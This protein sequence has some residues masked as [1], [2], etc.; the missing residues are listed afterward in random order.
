MQ[1]GIAILGSFCVCYRT[2]DPTDSGMKIYVTQAVLGTVMPYRQA[3]RRNMISD[4][5]END[6]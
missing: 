5:A 2:R 4:V 1:G 6:I 3:T